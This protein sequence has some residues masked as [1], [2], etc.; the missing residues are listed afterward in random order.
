MLL[1]GVCLT[2]WACWPGADQ[3]AKCMNTHQDPNWRLSSR[4]RRTNRRGTAKR[5]PNVQ[6]DL[7]MEAEA[8]LISAARKFLKN[9]P[10][11]YRQR[12]GFPPGSRGSF[13]YH[14]ILLSQSGIRLHRSNWCMELINLSDGK[15]ATAR[16][17][18]E[19]PYP[20]GRVNDIPSIVARK[21][22]RRDRI[23]AEYASS[24]KL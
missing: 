21:G 16:P 6:S 24:I 22:G 14:P 1:L 12:A 18:V 3:T 11:Y 8:A 2:H 5:I 10:R 15:H 4:A 9:C 20:Q 23:F 19:F 7:T 13:G 17:L